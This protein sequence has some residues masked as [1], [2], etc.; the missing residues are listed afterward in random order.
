M[1]ETLTYTLI[2]GLVQE[3]FTTNWRRT[4]ELPEKCVFIFKGR[5]PTKLNNKPRVPIQLTN[6]T[7][8]INIHKA[9]NSN[10]LGQAHVCH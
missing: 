1:T 6:I 10:T 3:K 5:L 2:S 7:W 9:I 8:A 4:G